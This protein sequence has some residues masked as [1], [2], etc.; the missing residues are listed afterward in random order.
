MAYSP[1][2]CAALKESA[3]ELIKDVRDKYTGTK[4]K[5]NAAQKKLKEKVA[6]F[7]EMYC[8]SKS[9]PFYGQLIETTDKSK[10][11]K[12]ELISEATIKR[13]FN[14]EYSKGITRIN[15]HFLWFALC[16]EDTYGPWEDNI[17]DPEDQSLKRLLSKSPSLYLIFDRLEDFVGREKVFER[18]DKFIENEDRGYFLLLGDPG[19]GKSAI[20]GQYLLKHTKCLHY[21]ISWQGKNNTAKKFQKSICEQLINTYSLPYEISEDALTDGTLLSDLLGA[22][23]SREAADGHRIKIIIDALDEANLEAQGGGNIFYLPKAVPKNVYFLMT[24]RRKGKEG[25]ATRL[26]FNQPF[27]EYDLHSN[28]E[29]YDDDIRLYVTHVLAENHRWSKGIHDWINRQADIPDQEKFIEDI[30]ARSDGNFMYAEL[31]LRELANP[32]GLYQSSKL[33]KLPQGLTNYYEDHWHFMGMNDP[34]CPQIKFDILQYYKIELSPVSLE[35]IY[36]YL[37]PDHPELKRHHIQVIID[38]W[39]QFLHDREIKETKRFHFYHKSY[40]DFLNTKIEPEP[41]RFHRIIGGDLHQ[42]T[43]SLIDGNKNA[44]DLW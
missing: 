36:N 20:A 16:G 13:F 14:P 39:R 27:Y 33:D 41:S 5:N 7:N 32:N 3:F 15:S 4:E 43:L 34:N 29:E 37:Y 25:S 11:E 42:Q 30:T 24:S 1:R 8:K 12:E 40:I 35:T 18:I 6:S 10:K 9:S 22:A 21:F 2:S 26:S 44:K 19:E 31:V 38:G 23:A 17:E 28:K